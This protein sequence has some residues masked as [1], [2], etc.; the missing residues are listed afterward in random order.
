M[1]M[2]STLNGQLNFKPIRSSWL[3]CASGLAIIMASAG[4]AAAQVVIDETEIFGRER[5]D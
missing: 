5:H 3:V 4:G 2:K 1:T